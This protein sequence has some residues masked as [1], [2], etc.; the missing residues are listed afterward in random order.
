MRLAVLAALTLISTVSHAAYDDVT[1][2]AKLQ[3]NASKFKSCT[4]AQ[5]TLQKSSLAA[6]KAI[7]TYRATNEKKYSDQL[8]TIAIRAASAT[9][10]I[11]SCACQRDWKTLTARQ[12]SD[13]V[14]AGCVR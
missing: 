9:R 10:Y 8:D 7:A 5:N 1:D 6:E 12:V 2:F 14:E 4:Q 11:L 3:A 13:R